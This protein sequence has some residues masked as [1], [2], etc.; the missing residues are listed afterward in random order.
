MT[1][2]AQEMLNFLKS[3]YHKSDVYMAEVLA[4]TSASELTLEEA[5]E[6]YI[7]SMNWS[8]G[9][10]FYRR[11]GCLDE[12]IDV[13]KKILSG[14]YAADKYLRE[15]LDSICDDTMRVYAE[16]AL[17]KVGLAIKEMEKFDEELEVLL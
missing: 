13:Q 3:E 7:E 10:K 12:L 5:F 16:S 1:E 15:D 9:D 11:I 14:L 17:K 6:V 8:D 2:K 4:S